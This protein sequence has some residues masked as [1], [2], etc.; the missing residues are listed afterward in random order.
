MTPERELHIA[1]INMDSSKCPVHEHS[2]WTTSYCFLRNTTLFQNLALIPVP[3]QIH[4]TAYFSSIPFHI[5]TCCLLRLPN[6]RILCI[7]FAYLV[8]HV[9]P[10]P[11][12]I[13]EMPTEYKAESA[14]HVFS[15][16]LYNFF[17][18][19]FQ[20]MFF[21]SLYSGTGKKQVTE[22]KQEVKMTDNVVNTPCVC[23][24]DSACCCMP[25]C[26]GRELVAIAN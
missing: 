9:L 16:F 10:T 14:N 6:C 20:T 26:E 8:L 17:C 19:L 25:S 23:F 4:C 7:F 22:S 3:S 12:F 18:R 2:C 13:I 1:Q 21:P 5:T 15:L 24:I 11:F